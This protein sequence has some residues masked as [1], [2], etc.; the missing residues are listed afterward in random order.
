MKIQLLNIVKYRSRCFTGDPSAYIDK[1][2][3]RMKKSNQQQ[4]TQCFLKEELPE[5]KQAV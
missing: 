4:H 3:D 1:K 2:Y 5:N